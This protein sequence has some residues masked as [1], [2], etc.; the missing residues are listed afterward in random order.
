MA[1]ANTPTGTDT[2]ATLKAYEDKMNAQIRDAKAKLE[3][4]EAKAA[5]QG[6]QAET[7]AIEQLKT[8]R[9]NLEQ[10]M[11][12]LK[13]TQGANLERAQGDI[14][15]EVAKLHTSIDKLTAQ[16]NTATKK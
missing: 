12:D 6:A 11:R 15:A 9:Q 3:Q 13:T 10:K 8:T 7:K 16:F 2:S 14:S 1:T 4:F 5:T